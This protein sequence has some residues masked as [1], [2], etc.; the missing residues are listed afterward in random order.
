[1]G[2]HYNSGSLFRVD[3]FKQLSDFID[4]YGVQPV[5][6]LVEHKYFRLVEQR[7]RKRQTL[8][9][10]ERKIFHLSVPRVFKPRRRK[11]ISYA[12]FV[13]VDEQSARFHVLLRR[14]TVVKSGGFHYAAHFSA[15]FFVFLVGCRAVYGHVTVVCQSKPRHNTHKRRLARAVSP[16]K[17]E[18]ISLADI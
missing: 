16:H 1:M 17:S 8:L 3:F 18:N 5:D 2:R 15:L 7:Q 12:G 6:R 13:R 9:H 4:A 10:A 11:N 14:K